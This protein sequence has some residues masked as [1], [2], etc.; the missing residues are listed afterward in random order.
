MIFD[1]AVCLVMFVAV[2]AGFN[3]GI[4]RSTATILAYLVAMPLAA[5]ATALI[6]PAFAGNG[7]AAT[8]A[9]A[10]N[11]FL[12]F[13]VF[14]TIG[15][16]LGAPLRGFVNEMVGERIGI[17]DRLAGSG[18]AAIRIGL[19]AVL[20]VVIF[21][22][23]IPADIEPGF[24]R[25]SRLRPIL[26]LAGQKGLKSLSPETTAFIDQLKKERGI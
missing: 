8:A 6:A 1:A 4:V 25:G 9:W 10:R 5:S 13:G 3:A 2:I 17:A 7:D 18:L 11:S 15:V 22:R 19:V 21:D 23:I 12:F 24:L 16:V 20:V 14:L 26:S